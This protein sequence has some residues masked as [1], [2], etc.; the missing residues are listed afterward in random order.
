MELEQWVGLCMCG[1]MIDCL[2]AF[3]STGGVVCSETG[4][5]ETVC[6]CEVADGSFEKMAASDGRDGRPRKLIC[7]SAGAMVVAGCFGAEAKGW[8]KNFELC[9]CETVD[10][11]LAF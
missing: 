2:L 7:S 1:A 4:V 11:V 8:S 10:C 6:T 3:G 9:M 5:A